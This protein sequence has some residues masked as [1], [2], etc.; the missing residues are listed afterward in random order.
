MIGKKYRTKHVTIR[1]ATA[2]LARYTE[3]ARV[4]P[5]SRNKLMNYALT[6]QVDL[7]DEVI[8]LADMEGD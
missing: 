2:T 6:K 8:E 1:I 7:I 3:I 5:H 4:S